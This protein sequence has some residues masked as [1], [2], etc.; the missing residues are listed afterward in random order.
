M[1]DDLHEH[2]LWILD[3]FNINYLK[4]SE[5][6]TKMAINFAKIYGLRRLINSA[7]HL[8]GF[9][10]TCIDLIFTNA[11]FIKFSGVLNDVL[12]DHYP[13]YVCIKKPREVHV[14]TYIH[15]RT[16]TAYDKNRFQTMLGNMDWDSYFLE[17]NPNVL[18]DILT[19]NIVKINSVMCPL[20][21]IKVSKN[22]PY[23]LSHHMRESINE[24]KKLYRDA[25][26]S[27]DPTTLAY[28]HLLGQPEIELIN[29]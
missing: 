8:I 10:G 18:W 3:D 1:S 23:W 21:Q 12:S 4:R 29:S 25:K 20:K 27:G 6:S 28:L 5:L 19:D 16:Y 26:V 14:S 2:E 11:G 9:G 13:I 15:G 17:T 7:T 24:R 22:K